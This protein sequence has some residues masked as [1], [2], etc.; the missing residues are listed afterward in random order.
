MS[1]KS[2]RIPKYCLHK[3]TGLARVIIDGRHVYL[4]VYGSDESRGQYGRL[5]AERFGQD[6]VPENTS[7]PSPAAAITVS[8][9]VLRY[10]QDRVQP[11]YQKN[12]KATDRQSHM[13]L[14]LAP[15]RRLYGKT[16]AVEF[17][18]RK[19][20]AVREDIIADGYRRRGGLNRKYVN[21][22]IRIIKRMFRWCV[23]EELLPRDQ[24]ASLC[25]AL[26]SVEN[27][28]KNED[29]RVTESTKVKSVPDGDVTRTLPF[30]SPQIRTMVQLLQLTGMRP[31][32]VTVMRPMD[33][34]QRKDIWLYRPELHKLEHKDIE[35][36]VPLGPTAQELL[37]PWL[38][39]N[40]TA[41]LFSPREVV[42]ANHDR[43]R[44]SQKTK[45]NK[46]NRRQ[47]RDHYDDESLCQAV[48]R[49]CDKASVPKW[50]PGQLRHSVA[51]RVTT[52]FDRETARQLLG[53]GSASTTDIYVDEQISE[54]IAAM[55]AVG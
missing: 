32:E 28:R 15:L 45:V 16:L 26:D 54:A 43:R 48:T 33:I 14:A 13:R 20:K 49:A 46:T 9:L 6:K 37:T 2:N 19:L 34:S 24:G 3:P 25:N 51:T 38:N 4:G 8:E 41:Y 44:K 52:Q 21:D 53:H 31:D 7:P 40:Q 5:I 29:H 47:P 18:P 10:W 17:G 1:T 35:R 23:G 30:M 36:I 42:E 39:R 55:K 22:H 27:L 11:L 50:T 12:G